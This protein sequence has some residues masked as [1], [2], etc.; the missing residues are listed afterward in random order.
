MSRNNCIKTL[1]LATLSVAVAACSGPDLSL[2]KVPKVDA[3]TLVT[4]NFSEFQKR[5][6]ARIA[7]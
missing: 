2:I 7:M 6:E 4:P 1:T 5:E 3:G